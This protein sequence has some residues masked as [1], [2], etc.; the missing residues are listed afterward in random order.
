[1]F[2]KSVLYVNYYHYQLYKIKIKIKE[3][4]KK[5]PKKEKL[6]YIKEVEEF[7]TLHQNNLLADRTQS[8]RRLPLQSC[9]NE[10]A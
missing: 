3:K 1:M 9:F 10:Q 2:S 8:F 4:K 7:L 6:S 5:K